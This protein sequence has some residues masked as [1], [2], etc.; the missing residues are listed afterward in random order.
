MEYYV[1]LKKEEILLFATT[2]MDREGI[3]KLNEMSQMKK[4][5][6]HLIILICK[7]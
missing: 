5:K 6:Y 2:W 1:A 3:I 7:I 4:D